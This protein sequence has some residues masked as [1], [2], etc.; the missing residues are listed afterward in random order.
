MFL[1]HSK[2]NMPIVFGIAPFYVLKDLEQK[3]K[4]LGVC[5]DLLDQN[6]YYIS[7]D[8][9]WYGTEKK[10]TKYQRGEKEKIR[11]IPGRKGN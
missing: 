7:D 4:T 8:L 5:K 11:D 1:A 3:V 10:L 2:E 6:K 9:E